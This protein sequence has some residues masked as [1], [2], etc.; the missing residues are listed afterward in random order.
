M[1]S[2]KNR[3]S[4]ALRYI[5]LLLGGAVS[6]MPMIYMLSTSLRPNG[7][8]YEFP[9]HFFPKLSE[10]TLENYCTSSRRR[11]SISTSSTAS[12]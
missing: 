6:V 3:W 5:L 10:I 2:R 12:S 11:N 7:A 1:K 8:L 4:L 9:P